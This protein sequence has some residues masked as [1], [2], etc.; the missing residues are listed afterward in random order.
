MGTQVAVAVG[1]VASHVHNLSAY[2]GAPV[3]N[4]FQKGLKFVT[5][6]F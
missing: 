2:E 3:T 1:A 5:V 6:L 4:M